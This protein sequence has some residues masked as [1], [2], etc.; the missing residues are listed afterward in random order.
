M[1]AGKWLQGNGKVSKMTESEKKLQGRIV[2]GYPWG[3]PK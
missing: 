1:D 2:L 3:K